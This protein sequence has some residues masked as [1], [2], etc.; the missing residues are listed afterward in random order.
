MS[1]S[2]DS[3]PRE[4]CRLAEIVQYRCDAERADGG[5]AQMHCLP[6]P[7]IF[8]IC[9]NRPA[10]E[11]TRFVDV[12]LETGAIHIPAQASQVLPKGKPWRD[13]VRYEDTEGNEV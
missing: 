3:K 12:D 1:D 11:M 8:R 5:R 9:R 13:V 4:Q 7:R 10:V 6:V 2:P